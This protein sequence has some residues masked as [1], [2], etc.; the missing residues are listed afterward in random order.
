MPLC[1]DLVELQLTSPKGR[2]EVGREKDPTF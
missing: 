1:W 2:W